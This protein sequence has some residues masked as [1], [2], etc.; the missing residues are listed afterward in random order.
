MH[1]NTVKGRA[2]HFDNPVFDI[3]EIAHALSMQC[4]FGGHT[5]EFYSI[6]EHSVM[7]SRMVELEKPCFSDNAT[8]YEGLM[9]DAHEAYVQDIVRPMKEKLIEYKRIEANVEAAMRETFNLPAKVSTGVKLAD[10]FALFVEAEKLLPPH[11]T[12]HWFTPSP[13]FHSLLKPIRESCIYAP[14]S[15]E[16][17]LAKRRFLERFYQLSGQKRL[18]TKLDVHA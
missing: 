10:W 16:P 2:F 14:A 6:A 13:T 8:P 5:R 17:R 11:T 1:I 7:V 9:H 18:G 3:E 12:D 15:W 4:R